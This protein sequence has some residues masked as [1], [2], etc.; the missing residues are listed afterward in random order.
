MQPCYIQLH[1]SIHHLY[2]WQSLRMYGAAGENI[3]PRK[4]SNI[5]EHNT[6]HPS[7]PEAN[8]KF[9]TGKNLGGIVFC[10]L[11]RVKYYDSLICGF[12]VI[13]NFVR[14]TRVITPYFYSLSV[15]SSVSIIIIYIHYWCVHLQVIEKANILTDSIFSRRLV[16]WPAICFKVKMSF[17]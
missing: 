10:S 6:R 5:C 4:L 15:C 7:N 1:F 17:V 3:H 9:P 16:I 8:M 14:H 11:H 13:N 12:W 2:V